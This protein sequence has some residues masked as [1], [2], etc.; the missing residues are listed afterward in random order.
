M[1]GITFVSFL[2]LFVVSAVVPVSLLSSFKEVHYV[3]RESRNG[4]QGT[5]GAG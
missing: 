3:R 1:M 2:T 4:D 5:G